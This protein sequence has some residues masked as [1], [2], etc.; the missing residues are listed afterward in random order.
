MDTTHV[1]FCVHL[2]HT[3]AYNHLT[4]MTKGILCRNTLHPSRKTTG[5]H[6][7]NETASKLHAC[8]VLLNLLMK[9]SIKI[10]WSLTPHCYYPYDIFSPYASNSI[11][12]KHQL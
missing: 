6:A 10:C 8:E 11:T 9:C 5:G 3:Q 2:Q 1:D 12:I 7:C 4:H